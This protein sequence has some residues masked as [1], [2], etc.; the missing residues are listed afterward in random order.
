M[1][2]LPHRAQYPSLREA[3]QDPR[4]LELQAPAADADALLCGIPY[5]GAV[6]GR[7][8]CAGG[9]TAIRE[10]FRF[11]ATHDPDMGVDL[12]LLRWHDLGDVALP[13]PA[14][15]DVLSIH[16]AVRGTLAPA[17]SARAGEDAPPPAIVLG[18]DNSLSFP[19]FQALHEAYGG[20]WGVLVLDAHYDV[21]TYSGQP[22]SGT[23]YGRILQE[24]EGRPV[25]A[26]NMVHI[27][28]RP[29]ANSTQLAQRA[30]D[31]G[32]EPWTVGDV[33]EHGIADVVDDA[34]GRVGDG[35]DHIFLSVD[36]DVL[37]QSVAPGV[38]APG[39]GGLL[40]EEVAEA[41]GECAYDP[42]VRAMDLVECAPN[43]DPTGN[44]PRCAAYLVA[45]FLGGV[46]ARS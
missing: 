6:I 1:P 19:T 26:R 7:K 41:V 17:L 39:I 14:H 30:A 5:D 29:F 34:L 16:D 25:M 27:G 36:L 24:L 32:L 9:P 3:P 18:G 38:S 45:E 12:G 22:T 46:A 8:G 28:I 20:K 13:D 43:L 4:F 44:T 21:R 11:L 15:P 35:V 42:R 33:R 40:L 23:P 31:L 10:A 37:D 2:F